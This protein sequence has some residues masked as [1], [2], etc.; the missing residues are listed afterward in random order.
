MAESF[1][2]L[3]RR[4]AAGDGRIIHGGGGDIDPPRLAYADNAL[5]FEYA[6][7]SFD[8]L[9]ANRYQVLLEGVDRDWSEWRADGYKDYNNLFEGDY[10]FQV[11]ARN[12][13]GTISAPATFN[14]LAC[15][16]PGIAVA[17]LFWG[18][19]RVWLR[20]S[21]ACCAGGLAGCRR[22]G[23]RWS[24]SLPERTHQLAHSA[25]YGREVMAQL[26]LDDALETLYQQLRRVLDASVFGVGLHHPE[27]REIEFRIAYESGQRYPPYVRRMN[28]KNQLAGLVHRATPGDPDR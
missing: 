20:W 7:T 16:R 25:T 8:G 1:H 15:C 24:R 18:I 14:F 28:D 19:C 17:S 22:G 21:Q 26:D 11:R 3:L 6:A 9:D 12:L 2:A 4:V 10:R 13:Y 23:L 5:R 27:F